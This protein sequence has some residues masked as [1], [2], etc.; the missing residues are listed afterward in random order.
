MTEALLALDHFSDVPR[1][2]ALVWPPGQAADQ[3]Q[4]VVRT[5]FL[6][7]RALAGAAE[8]A[9][10][11][12]LARLIPFLAEKVSQGNKP[13]GYVCQRGKCEL[14]TTD[15]TVLKAQLLKLAR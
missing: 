12:A 8:G 3:L 13:T 14:P 2:V 7:N 6:P 1:E 15:P 4:A 10:L 5:T 9:G 11:E